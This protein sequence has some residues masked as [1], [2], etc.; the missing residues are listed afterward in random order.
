MSHND[1]LVSIENSVNDPPSADSDSIMRASNLLGSSR[2]WVLSQ[3][4]D[5][6]YYPLKL[7][8]GEF[9]QVA[10]RSGG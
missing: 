9:V 6:C 1:Q 8:T 2:S 4:T 7:I 5:S 10:L 3:A